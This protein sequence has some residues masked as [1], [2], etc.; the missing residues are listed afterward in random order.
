MNRKR[1]PTMLVFVLVAAFG[2]AASLMG[3]GV[4]HASAPPVHAAAATT[5]ATPTPEPPPGATRV[6]ETDGAVMVYVPA[7]EFLMGSPIGEGVLYEWPQHIVY[8][9]GYWIDRTE[10]TN[11]QFE[12]FVKATGYR[13]DAEKEGRGWTAPGSQVEGADWRHPDGPDSSIAGRTDDPVLQVSWNDGMAYCQWAGARLP[14]G[15]QWEK[16]AR[17][18]DE[19]RYPWGNQAPSCEYTVMRDE[20]GPACGHGERPLPVGS[21]PK[22]ASPY[23]VLDMAG[24]VFKWLADYWEPSYY[25]HS[26]ASNPQGPERGDSVIEQ[27]GCWND[28]LA[29]NASFFLLSCRGYDTPTESDNATGFR[30][31]VSVPA[32]AAP[33]EAATTAIAPGPASRVLFIGDD[34]SWFLDRYLPKLAASGAPPVV[35]ESKALAAAGGTLSV[36]HLL[37]G[38]RYLLEEIGSGRWNVVVLQQDL[39]RTWETADKFCE[40]AGKFHEQVKQ[41]GAETILFMPWDNAAIAPPPTLED[42]AEVY[43]QCGAELGVKVAPVGLAFERAAREQPGLNLFVSDSAHA[44]LR[45]LYL[46]VCVLYATLFERSPVG[47]AY[48]MDDV[49]T[50]SLEYALWGLDRQKDWQLSADDAAFLQRIAWETVQDYQAQHPIQATPTAAK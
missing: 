17:G 32:P 3:Y 2:L 5:T 39:D 50:W 11:R 26:P 10:V 28:G 31:A 36:Y 8:L 42:T 46:T 30:C 22:G 7:G 27:C 35:I 40:D 9:D 21:K 47:L 4:L 23:G 45:G 1:C 48:R 24:N 25:A 38:L 49:P 13:T 15:A 14:T 29:E 6:R 43:S 34:D 44:N 19:R 20:S 18:T 37:P 33:A 41:A 12:L 16:A